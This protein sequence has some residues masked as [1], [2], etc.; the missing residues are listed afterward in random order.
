MGHCIRHLGIN[1]RLIMQKLIVAF[2]IVILS[3]S[4]QTYNTVV[5]IAPKDTVVVIK[6]ATQKEINEH[7]KL[8]EE[9]DSVFQ[10][11]FNFIEMNDGEIKSSR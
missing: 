8:F 4:C 7:D 10:V 3:V 6:A 2:L 5:Y 11:M 1:N 9:A